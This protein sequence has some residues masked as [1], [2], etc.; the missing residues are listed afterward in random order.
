MAA[1][2]SKI[3]AS[4]EIL[5]EDAI[6]QRAE[7]FRLCPQGHIDR[8]YFRQR[9]I[10]KPGL[11]STVIS[12]I[13]RYLKKVASKLEP[14]ISTWQRVHAWNRVDWLWKER[15]PGAELKVDVVWHCR[16]S[17]LTLLSFSMCG[18]GPPC[19]RWHDWHPFTFTGECS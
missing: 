14:W 7:N 19:G 16:Q 15:A 8:E 17:K 9:L 13:A 18:L 10:R 4:A 11:S 5:T 6:G 2:S 12:H 1:G 3:A